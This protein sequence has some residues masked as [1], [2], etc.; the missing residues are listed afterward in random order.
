MRTKE[1]EKERHE[2]FREELYPFAH[3]PKEQFKLILDDFKKRFPFLIEGQKPRPMDVSW[4]QFRKTI[5]NFY[6]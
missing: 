4:H 1:E 6:K 3:L 5:R 2:I